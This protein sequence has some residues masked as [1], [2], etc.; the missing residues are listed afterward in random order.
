MPVSLT[1]QY[2]DGTNWILNDADQ[3]STTSLSVTDPILADGLIPSELCVLDAGSPGN[4]NLGC[5]LADTSIKKFNE[6]PAAI[7]PGDFNLN[8]KAPGNGNI[9]SLDITADTEDYLKYNWKGLGSTN[10][11]ARVTFG[12]YK[13]NSKQIYFREVY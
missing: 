13:G 7:N 5:S 11:T 4:S 6:P 2:W 8:F 3:C 12:I 9:G 1:T 10:P